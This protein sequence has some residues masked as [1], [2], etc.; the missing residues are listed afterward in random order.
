MNRGLHG[1]TLESDQPAA[2]AAIP[3]DHRDLLERPLTAA[4]STLF[5]DGMA[6]TQPVWFSYDPPYLLINTMR[7][8]RKERNLRRD[9]RATLLTID[10][11]NSSRWL[12]VRG[13]TKLTEVGAR[14]HLDSLAQR[15]AG[16]PRFLDGCVPARLAGNEV[17]VIGRIWP[18]RVVDESCG[19]RSHRRMRAPRSVQA[20]SPAAHDPIQ[21]PVSH[22]DL[23]EKP[24]VAAL[25]TLM[26]GGQPQTEP[27]WF[28]IDDG[29]VTFNTTRE[30]QRGRNLERDGRATML[31]VD[32]E[33][34]N[35]WIEIRGDVDIQT[36]GA[37]EHLDRLTRRYT[38]WPAF[39][40]YVQPLERQRTDSRIIVRLW[41]RHVV[42]DAV[43][44]HRR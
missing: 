19:E 5:A 1:A 21:L 18:L 32:P 13:I 24:V 39:Y 43:Y 17:P 42:C 44:S 14:A 3:P 30:R 29:T 37:L 8:F 26:P 34:E 23:L 6:Q 25:T 41:P 16:V 31:V 27:V 36:E 4:L 7:G 2:A 20:A 15:Y 28:S 22:R 38:P 9:P 35:R 33:N 10:P 11:L 12:E 40:G